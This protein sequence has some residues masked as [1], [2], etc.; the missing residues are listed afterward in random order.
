MEQTQGFRRFCQSFA[1]HE[2]EP[3]SGLNTSF[4]D[5]ADFADGYE[6]KTNG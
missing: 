3:G 1:D 6:V 5:F 4:A 2:N